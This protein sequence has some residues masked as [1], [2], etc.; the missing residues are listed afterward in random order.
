MLP[1]NPEDEISI[2]TKKL[3]EILLSS[4]EEFQKYLTRLIPGLKNIATLYRQGME[5]EANQHYIEAI[6]GI[7]VM[8]ELIQGLGSSKSLDFESAKYDGKSL[9]D[10]TERLKLS[11]Q[12]LV[13]A[14]A[15]ED[16]G[17]L[18]ELLD[19]D[20]SEE[21]TLWSEVMPALHKELLESE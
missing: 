12:R 11:V 9:M 19:N 8:I 16:T 4:V 17:K 7:R 20:I 13:E 10:L 2:V 18:A 6:D 15:N 3:H 14:Q 5:G 1:Y 21:L